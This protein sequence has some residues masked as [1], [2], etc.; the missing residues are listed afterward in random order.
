[1]LLSACDNGAPPHQPSREK[2][3]PLVEVAKAA[4]GDSSMR[5]ERSGELRALRSVNVANQ[6]EGVV[7][8]VLV[9]E[10]DA[11][12]K[13][14]LLLIL[15]A[16]VLRA[17]LNRANI[18]LKQ[19]QAYLARLN[20]LGDKKLVAGQTL[21]DARAK[22]N[23]ARADTRLLQEKVDHLRV[24]AP[25]P[26]V[27]T[28]KRVHA[29]DV[30]ARYTH[31]LTLLDP[32]SLVTTFTVPGAIR[33][34]LSKGDPVSI[35]ID[36]LGDEDYAGAISRLSPGIDPRTRL[37][38]VEAILEPAPAGALPGQF[39]RVILGQDMPIGLTI[40]VAALR[41]DREGEY[42]YFV[43]ADRHVHK[44]PVRAGLRL[45]ERV[46]ILSGLENGD[47]VVISGFLSLHDGELVRVAGER[48]TPE[49]PEIK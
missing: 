36:S 43:G 20:K 5:F 48:S 21:A 16:P 22:R 3:A 39:A 38:S 13:G 24:F 17:E 18:Q 4:P 35:R 11:V 23:L 6:Q 31:L 27:I 14:Q 42:V 26:G 30:A 37:S 28:E 9:E 8:R 40:P 34:R 2:T 19:A 49:K 7:S 44:R 29:G 47:E 45:H 10:G 1:M 41:R 32:S 46:E 33:S 25:F 12:T 15:D